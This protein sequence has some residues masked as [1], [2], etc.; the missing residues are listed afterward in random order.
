MLLEEKPCVH[1]QEAPAFLTPSPT[2]LLYLCAAAVV[3][4]LSGQLPVSFL[5]FPILVGGSQLLLVWGWQ[6]DWSHLCVPQGSL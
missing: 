6:Q 5:F 3:W 2:G 1:G 4:L